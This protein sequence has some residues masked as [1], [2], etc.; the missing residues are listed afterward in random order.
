MENR[1]T[2][3]LLAVFAAGALIGVGATLLLKPEP[4]FARPLV[5]RL[6]ESGRD[7]RKHARRSAR[8]AGARG[9]RLAR[10]GREILE[11]FRGE[12][13]D[14]VGQAREELARQ[15]YAEMRGGKGGRHRGRRLKR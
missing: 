6:R 15:V 1:D 14:I 10:A 5:R 9:G 13:S 4:A 3:E 7:L 8:D 11:Q 12:A 2:I